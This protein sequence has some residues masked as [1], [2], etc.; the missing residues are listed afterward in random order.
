M[1]AKTKVYMFILA[2]YEC[3]LKRDHVSSPFAVPLIAGT[4]TW[5]P[6]SPVMSVVHLPH[7]HGQA[8]LPDGARSLAYD[9][10]HILGGLVC[11]MLQAATC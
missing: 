11:C 3:V 2:G 5:S 10:M 8:Q 4:G 6:E 9:R 1:S 7:S